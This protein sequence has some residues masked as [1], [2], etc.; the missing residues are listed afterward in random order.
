MSLNNTAV[1]FTGKPLEISLSKE[2]IGR[3]FN[4]TGEP[5]DGRGPVYSNKKY[6]VNG[7]PINPLLVNIQEILFKQAFH[8]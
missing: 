3:E 8:L 4:G 7:R 5:I 1:S 2:V 6:N